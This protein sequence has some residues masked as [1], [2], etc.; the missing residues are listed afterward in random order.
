MPNIC[1][2]WFACSLPSSCPGKVCVFSASFHFGIL[3]LRCFWIFS[4]KDKLAPGS[5]PYTESRKIEVC[6][7]PWC[8]LCCLVLAWSLRNWLS[9]GQASL[10]VPLDLWLFMVS[11]EQVAQRGCKRPIPGNIRHQVE[12]GSEQ[13]DLVENVPA[14]CRECW[15]R[16]F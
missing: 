12:L 13:S 3:F 11:V 14:H 15:S 9:S 5:T 1:H 7:S 8:N 16:W 6:D 4:S 2:M 10:T